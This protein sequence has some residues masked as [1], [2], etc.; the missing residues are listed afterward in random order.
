MW[1]NPLPNA[2]SRFRNVIKTLRSVT[3]IPIRT[4]LDRA[5]QV[6]LAA[7][8]LALSGVGGLMAVA[9]T[10][11]HKLYL[12]GAGVVLLAFVLSAEKD[13]EASDED[14]SSG[15]GTPCRMVVTA[16][17]LNVRAE[18]SQ[19]AAVVGTLAEG[20][21]VTADT[22]TDNGFRLLSEGRWAFEDYLDE[23]DGDC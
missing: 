13:S 11:K 21:E 15:P 23:S 17:V 9:L 10:G 16:D 14:K 4:D 5:S 7:Q 8:E 18:A 1:S 6:S 22:E 2:A 20:Q 12:A 19:T 3:E